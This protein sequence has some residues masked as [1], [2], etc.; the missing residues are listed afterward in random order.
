MCVPIESSRY[1]GFPSQVSSAGL[2]RKQKTRPVLE[3]ILIVSPYIHNTHDD[4]DDTSNPHE[5]Y[6]L[7][8]DAEKR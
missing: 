6:T 3:R 2:E 5:T 8:Q 7:G 4:D 1:R